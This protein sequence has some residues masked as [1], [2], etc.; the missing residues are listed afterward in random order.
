M[1]CA[2]FLYF[3]FYLFNYCLLFIDIILLFGFKRKC[4]PS[5][6][7]ITQSQYDMRIT[8]HLLKGGGLILWIIRE[9]PQFSTGHM[10]PPLTRTMLI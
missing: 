1:S 5:L 9:Y 7:I 6:P 10:F 2:G 8:V 4:Q 3:A